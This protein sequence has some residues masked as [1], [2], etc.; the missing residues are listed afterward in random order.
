M[1]V[2]IERNATTGRAERLE[3]VSED[4]QDEKN[5][6]MIWKGLAKKDW[7]II[8]REPNDVG[9]LHRIIATGYRKDGEE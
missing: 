9:S 3:L 6:E 8:I 2:R 7:Q 5:I 4:F 1:R